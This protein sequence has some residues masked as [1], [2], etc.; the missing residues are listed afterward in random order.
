MCPLTTPLELDELAIGRRSSKLRVPGSRYAPRH[1]HAA[2]LVALLGEETDVAP[3]H[4]RRQL[5]VQPGLGLQAARAHRQHQRLRH[6]QVSHSPTT[7]AEPACLPGPHTG[8]FAPPLPASL[9]RTRARSNSPS[10][11]RSLPSL[12]ARVAH[13]HTPPH[14]AARPLTRPLPPAG[15]TSTCARARSTSPSAPASSP[16]APRSRH[17]TVTLRAP[18]RPACSK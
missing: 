10:L 16:T 3:S 14:S 7:L 12:A 13:R 6:R 8:P 9:A 4:R 2:A 1:A 17:R 15:V 11:P 5:E 18:E